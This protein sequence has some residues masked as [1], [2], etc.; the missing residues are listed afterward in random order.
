MMA[1]TMRRVPQLGIAVQPEGKLFDRP[2]GRILIA[3]GEY[4]IR[5]A[6][7]S[8]LFEAGFEVTEASGVEEAVALLRA[9]HCDL[10][11]LAVHMDGR[12]SVDICRELRSCCPGIPVLMLS[13]EGDERD[14]VEALEAGADDCISKPLRMN[15]VM[16]R[17]RALMRRAKVAAPLIP[18]ILRIGDIEV[19]LP[20]RTVCKSGRMVHLTPKEFDLLVYLMGHAGTAIPHGQLLTA[21]WGG[22]HASRVDYLRT[23]VRQL[24]RKLEDSSGTPRYLRTTNYVGY[25][26]ADTTE[27]ATG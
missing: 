12:D 2:T 10:A 25:R 6:L 4:S 5:R 20:R 11:M 16:A 19:N 26:F 23:F 1:P 9:I 24:R 7:H 3:D 21:V 15:E 8:A 27:V 13:A 14:Q 17:V 22:D 18:S